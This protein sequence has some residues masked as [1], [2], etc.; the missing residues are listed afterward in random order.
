MRT[1]FSRQI[2]AAWDAVEGILNYHRRKARFAAFVLFFWPQWWPAAK[3]FFGNSMAS[4][5]AMDLAEFI[6][7]AWPPLSP[8]NWLTIPLGLILIWVSGRRKH[9]AVVAEKTIDNPEAPEYPTIDLSQSSTLAML[10]SEGMGPAQIPESLRVP[11]AIAEQL[12]K[13]ASDERDLALLQG[14][15]L[16]WHQASGALHIDANNAGAITARGVALHII[17][18]N[19]LSNGRFV[20]IPEFPSGGALI[21]SRATGG[22]SELFP[23]RPVRF[24]G[25]T[26]EGDRCSM[27]VHPSGGGLDHIRLTEPGDYRVTW[28]LRKGH[29]F[30]D[31]RMCFGWSPRSA[32]VGKP[33]RREIGSP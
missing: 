5:F 19:L 16:T 28:R 11:N 10:H 25:F 14:I 30:R 12:A 33:C 15:S 1:P 8:W 23:D 27:Q 3:E 31:H 22:S 32:P 26:V 13:R 20:E 7:L 29:A 21:D 4:F 9:A 17:E 2:Q 24:I 6:G 18:V